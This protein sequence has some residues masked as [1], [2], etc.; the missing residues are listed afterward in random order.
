MVAA[1]LFLLAG[2]AAGLGATYFLVAGTV[3]VILM[4]EHLLVAP[5]DMSRVNVAFF[6]MNG[7]ISVVLF[8]GVAVDL[9]RAA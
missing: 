1:V 2:W 4:G 8:L 9:W 7:V 6:T 5:D 3:G